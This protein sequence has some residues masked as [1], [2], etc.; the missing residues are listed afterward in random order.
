MRSSLRIV[1]A[2]LLGVAMAAPA[3]AGHHTKTKTHKKEKK[4]KKKPKKLSL[5]KRPANMPDGWSWPPNRAMKAEGDR[6][7]AQLDELGIKYKKAK[8]TKKVA[9]PIT[10]EDMTLGG[11]KVTSWWRTGPFVMDCHLALGLATYNQGLYAL[12]VREIKFSSIYSNR[13]VKAFGKEEHALSRHALGLAID[14]HSFIDD[15]GNEAVVL[16]DYPKG[17]ELL[18]NVEKYLNDSGGFR[19]VLTP[20][21]D[22]W[23]HDDHFHIEVKVDYSTPTKKTTS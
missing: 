18:L 10:L 2:V 19:T 3:S 6:C 15:A 4:T 20:R 14:V 21:I 8:K 1:L 9:T 23:S 11:V 22:P 12:G 16:D 13:N 17:N 7:L 5:A